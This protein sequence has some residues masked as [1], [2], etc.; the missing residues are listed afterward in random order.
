MPVSR[1]DLHLHSTASDGR[2]SPADVMR[3]AAAAGVHLAALTD[4]D[5]LGGL[6][7]AEVAA[8]DAGVRLLPGIELS[9]R[10]ARGTLHIVGLGVDPL[11]GGLRAGVARHADVRHARARRI[12]ERLQRAGA[13]ALLDRVLAMTGGAPP[14]RQHF[15]RGLVE[16]GVVG[17]SKAAFRRYL[18]RGRPGYAPAEWAPLAEVVGWIRGAGGIAVFAHP[19]RYG[20]SR[21]ALREAVKAFVAADG[22]AMEVACGGYGPGDVGA[23]A[24][25]ARRHALLASAG[26]DFHD[27]EV[28]WIGIGRLA[29]LP[30]D[31]EPV[32]GR[33]M[34]G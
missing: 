33:W 12:A 9:A 20:L 17:D 23:A 32:W 22:T 24:A 1:V 31:L 13:P 11:A 21:G 30:A 14:G 2:L 16:A 4:H 10:W 3:R 18:A 27:P 15:A 6:A 29:P 28:P 25:L 19:T 34:P 7:Q 8:R 5:T 26:S